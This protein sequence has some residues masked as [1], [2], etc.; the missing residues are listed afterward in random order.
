ML[1]VNGSCENGYTEDAQKLEKGKEDTTN[2]H[3]FW[4]PKLI[5]SSAENGTTSLT[6]PYILLAF[7]MAMHLIFF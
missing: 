7:P 5:K 6:W 2:G 1:V 4:A 3:V